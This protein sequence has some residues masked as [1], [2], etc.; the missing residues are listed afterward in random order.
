MSRVM[1]TL[2]GLF[3]RRQ[4]VRVSESGGV[5][6]LHQSLLL[7]SRSPLHGS[8]INDV[9]SATTNRVDGNRSDLENGGIE[10][11]TRP[12]T[13]RVEGRVFN[14]DYSQVPIEGDE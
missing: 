8:N 2:I 14:G 5:R 6:E 13:E 11:A 9:D 4:K 1:A 3:C 10:L 12:L 7:D